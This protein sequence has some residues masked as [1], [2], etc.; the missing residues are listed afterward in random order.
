MIYF[1]GDPHFCSENIRKYENRPFK[2]IDTMDAALIENYNKIITDK[3]TVFFTGDFCEDGYER[4]ILA[5]LKGKKYLIKGN[6]DTKS[7][8]AYRD[9]GFIEVYDHPIILDNFWIVSHEPMY[10]TEMSPYVNIF[11]HVHNNPMYKTY[12]QRSFCTCVDRND[13]KPVSFDCIKKSIAEAA[14]CEYS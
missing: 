2:D 8:S 13:F 3:D 14:V 7:N 1:Y 4:G 5:E 6:H 11:A 12:S 10:I 9:F